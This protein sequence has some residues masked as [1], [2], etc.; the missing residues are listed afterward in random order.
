[1]VDFEQLHRLVH[2]ARESTETISSLVNEL[3]DISRIRAGK[4]ELDRKAVSLS[5][6]VRRV[7]SL[8]AQEIAQAGTRIELRG[9][10]SVGGLWDGHRIE[11][12]VTNLLSNA[13]KYGERRPVEL[14]WRRDPDTGNAVLWVQDQGIGIPESLQQKIFHRFERAVSGDK[15]QGLGLGLYIV[16]QLVEAHGGKVSV[17]S[18]PG[19]GSLFLVE[20]PT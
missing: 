15:I 20:L 1:M 4:L 12:V 16:R 17:S 7:M 13:L 2:C 19:Q 8:M 18:A 6:I 14:G 3:L 9:D 10:D 5:A 11:Q